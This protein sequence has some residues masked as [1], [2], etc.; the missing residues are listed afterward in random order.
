[1]IEL[2][3]TARFQSYLIVVELEIRVRPFEVKPRANFPIGLIHG[4]A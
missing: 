3:F 2:E 1:L 4:I